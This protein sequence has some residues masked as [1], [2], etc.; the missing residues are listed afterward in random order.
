L[1]RR[2]VRPVGATV[3]TGL[4]LACASLA[5]PQEGPPQPRV[6]ILEVSFL[7]MPPSSGVEPTYHTAMWIEDAKGNLVKTLY[8]S[9]ELSSGEYRMG[10]ACPDWIKQAHWEKAPKAEVDA[11][12]APTPSVGSETKVFDLASLG[13]PPSTYQF[14]FQVH[15]TEQHNVLHRGALTV[16]PE[17]RAVKLETVIG[18][19]KMSATDQFVRDVEVRYKAPAR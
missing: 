9:Q 2:T 19:G 16:G 1:T 4:F 7:Y 14:K 13:V 3:C 10:E 6:G 11:V 17:S 15:I 12:T 18:P 8:V 5:N